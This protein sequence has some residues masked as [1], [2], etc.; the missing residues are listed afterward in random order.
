M[1]E[2]NSM[3]QPQPMPSNPEPLVNPLVSKTTNPL[4]IGL[5][6][7]VLLLL[8]ATGFLAYQNMQLQK[9]VTQMKT[10][11]VTVG[12]SPTPIA[13]ASQTP[14]TSATPDLTAGWK[15]YNKNNFTFKYPTDV[16]LGENSDSSVY[17]SKSGPTQKA[18][19]ESTDGITMLFVPRTLN[20]QTLEQWVDQSI[21]QSNGVVSVSEGKKATTLNG[22]SGF[23]YTITGLGTQRNII[24]QSPLSQTNFVQINNSTAD[25][26]NQG[27]ETVVNQILSTF[28]FTN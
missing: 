13:Y 4:M 23:T 7:L 18:Q 9:E 2:K 27:F 12:S 11:Q 19:T 6:V 26:T 15:T 28:K 10:S 1:D 8:G 17:L 22:Y 16:T 25:P 21:S 5:V 24:L 14:S 3:S 20:N